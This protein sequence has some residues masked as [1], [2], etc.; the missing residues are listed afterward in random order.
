MNQYPLVGLD[1]FKAFIKDTATTNDVL[2]SD[3]IARAS[4]MIESYCKRNF[5]S[6]SYTEYYDGN[7]SNFLYLDQWPVVGTTAEVD[8]YDDIDRDFSST[9]KFDDDDWVLS[10]NEGLV[11]LL[12]N[13]AV[14]AHWQTG[15]KNI[16]VI[17]TAGYDE[18]AIVASSNDKI[19]FNIGASELTATLTAGTYSA[20]TL[21]TE[22]DTQ[23]TAADATG[24]YTVSFNNVTCKFTLARSTGT[25][26]LLWTSGTNAATSVGDTLGYLTTANDTGATTYTADY[27]RP[28]LPDD[29]QQACIYQAYE[30]YL[31]GKGGGGDDRFGKTSVSISD[32]SGGTLSFA[33]GGLSAEVKQMLE[34]YRRRNI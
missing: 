22:I 13:A 21:C 10:N 17:Y 8:L 5:R 3:Y 32:P 1:K 20:A 23:L 18:F 6:R 25:F 30:F 26:Q 27:S 24:T 34:I 12:D 15:I 29:L 16:K 33:T 7:G 11:Q 28:G 2:Y 14:G 31:K 19:N 4:R 9:Y